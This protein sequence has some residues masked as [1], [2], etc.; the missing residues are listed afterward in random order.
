LW[1]SDASPDSGTE[2]AIPLIKRERE[3]EDGF[4]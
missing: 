4:V 1:S 2:L 3:G